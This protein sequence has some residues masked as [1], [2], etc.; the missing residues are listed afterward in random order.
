MSFTKALLVL[1]LS[2]CLGEVSGLPLPHEQLLH[3]NPTASPRCLS[4]CLLPESL[5]IDLLSFTS[6]P[7]QSLS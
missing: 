7:L 1:A 5:L 2:P 3:Q 6:N 4:L